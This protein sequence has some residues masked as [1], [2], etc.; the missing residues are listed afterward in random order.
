MTVTIE[1][2]RRI[3]GHPEPG[4]VVTVERTELIEALLEQGYIIEVES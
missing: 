1:Y 3:V 4:T 2:V